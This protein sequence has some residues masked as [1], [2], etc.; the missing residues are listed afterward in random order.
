MQLDASSESHKIFP[1]ECRLRGITYAAPLYATL[2]RK[3]DNEPEDKVTLQIGDIPV[4]VRSNFCNL[5]N[6]DEEE[7]VKHRED[8]AEF[9]GYFIINGNERLVRMIIMTKRNY[10]V[11]F[12]RSNFVN[13]G[14]L[15][16][17]YAVQM[18]CI[19][20]DLFA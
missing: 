12:H 19:R 16:T 9:G 10:P 7:L 8:M 15:F 18:R 17:P 5:A 13:R 3:I 6:M 4:M 11:A 1:T 2:C 20:D 14:K